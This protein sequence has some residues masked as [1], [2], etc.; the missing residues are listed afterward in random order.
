M[1]YD[2]TSKT[3]VAIR[4]F[5]IGGLETSLVVPFIKTGDAA[6]IV[7]VYPCRDLEKELKKKEGAR[8]FPTA[9]RSVCLS[10]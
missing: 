1:Y 3:M 5:K 2:L 8:C 6:K 7:T 4:K 10:L 9:F